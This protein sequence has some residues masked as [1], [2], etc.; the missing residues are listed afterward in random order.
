VSLP[1]RLIVSTFFGAALAS[2]PSADLIGQNAFSKSEKPF[3]SISRMFLKAPARDSLVTLT[4]S[5]VG[6]RYKLGAV[7]PGKAF[8]CSGLVQWVMAKFD[9]D[10]PRTS[11]EQAKLGREIP[12][13]PSQL[14]PGD[15]LVF[16]KG[17]TIDHIG[18]YV[19]NGKFVHAANRRKGVVEAPVPT[20]K[21]T[22]WKGVRRVFDHEIDVPNVAGDSLT[23]LQV[24]S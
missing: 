14:R 20:E 16:G 22:W 4:R 3:A 12:K 8:D 5:Q 17:R 21:S 11:K 13:D 1:R 18:I 24:V 15:L 2:T 9:V 6:L 23:F 10:L 7:L 19:G